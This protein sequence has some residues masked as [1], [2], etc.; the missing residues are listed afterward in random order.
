MLIVANRLGVMPIAGTSEELLTQLERKE[1]YESVLQG[2]NE[3]RKREWLSVRVLLKKLTGEEKLILYTD[4]GKPYLAD[5]S[6]HL[7]LS[8]TKGYAAVILDREK[9]VAIDVE[10]ISP[11]VEKVKTRFV[12]EAENAA[13]SSD[14]PLIHLL[15]YWSAK[16]S[17]FKLL[18]ENKL[19][20]KTQLHIHPF[21]PVMNQW[22]TFT[23]HE[24]YSPSQST[25][26]IH[27][28]VE[29]NYVLTCIHLKMR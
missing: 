10:Y 16:E 25:F 27:Y 17:L 12:N 4:S 9:P 26:T 5:H 3:N 11:R 29:K 19:E 8:H 24:T 2:M 23:A 1:W 14:N 20:F 22:A 7:S 15:L 18:D 6:F 28:R 21:E 13:L